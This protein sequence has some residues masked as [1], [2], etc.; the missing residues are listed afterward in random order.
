MGL[1]EAL[2]VFPDEQ[3]G[4]RQVDEEQLGSKV[5]WSSPGRQAGTS[6]GQPARRWAMAHCKHQWNE[7]SEVLHEVFTTLERRK[8]AFYVCTRCLK[9]DEVL[10]PPVT[11]ERPLVAVG[12]HVPA[13]AD[14]TDDEAAA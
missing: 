10:S 12:P 3:A 7:R 2:L 8:H 1:F 11:L 13:L 6:Q 4:W 5:A 9:I 14:P